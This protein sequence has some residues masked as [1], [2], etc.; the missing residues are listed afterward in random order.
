MFRDWQAIFAPTGTPIHVMQRLHAEITKAI[1]T[2]G[3]RQR[4][5][6]LGMEVAGVGPQQAL[7]RIRADINQV[8]QLITDMKIKAD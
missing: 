2:S 5:E 6:A 8:G 7:A 4:L 3:S 1:A